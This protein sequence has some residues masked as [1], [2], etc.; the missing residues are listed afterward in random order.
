[1]SLEELISTY[2][3]A[4]IGIGT[5]L[6]GETIL[7]LVGFAAHRGY[8]E[9]PWVIVFAIAVCPVRAQTALDF[10]FEPM[11]RFTR[12]HSSSSIGRTINKSGFDLG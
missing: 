1:M 12:G 6:E 5:F 11:S 8:L 7:I 10:A 9:L 4:A 2:G 3:Y